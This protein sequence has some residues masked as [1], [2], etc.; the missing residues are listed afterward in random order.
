MKEQNRKKIAKNQSHLAG[1][2][3]STQK[4]CKGGNRRMSTGGRGSG[5]E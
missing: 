1:L 2:K 3:K 4:V 5:Q